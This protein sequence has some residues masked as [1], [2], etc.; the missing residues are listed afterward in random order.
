TALQ[1]ARTQVAVAEAALANHVI[2]APFAGRLG[3]RQISVGSL[4][5]PGIVITTLDDIT[6]VEGD[7]EVPARFVGTLAPG[8]AVAAEAAAYPGQ[9]F[10]G[11]VAAIATRVDP[12]TR[13]LAVRAVLDNT[14]ARLKPGM[15]LTMRLIR[16]TAPALMIPEL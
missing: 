11:E 15:L 6:P 8:Q 3:L 14:E 4:V 16:D 13:T 2:S 9:G 7:F 5:Q 10:H 1:A 12:V